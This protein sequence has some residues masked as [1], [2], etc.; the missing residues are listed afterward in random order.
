MNIQELQFLARE[1]IPVKIIVFNNHS[2][3]MIRHFQEMYLGARFHETTEVGGYTAP[4]FAKVAEAYGIPSISIDQ[5]D[6]TEQSE[7]MLI[8]D[9]PALIE[10]KIFEN[11]YVV[12]KLE[13]GKPNQDQEPLIDRDLYERLMNLN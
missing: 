10:I 13:F 3:G 8:S 4:D 5:L 11:T 6:M 9:G 7:E 2:L 12:P 1:K